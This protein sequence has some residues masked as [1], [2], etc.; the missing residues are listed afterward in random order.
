[1][2]HYTLVLT[3]NPDTQVMDDAF[4]DNLRCSLSLPLQTGEPRW[5][6]HGVALELPLGS[7]L[8]VIERNAIAQTT[9]EVVGDGPIDINIVADGPD[10]RKRL[11]LADMDSTI[12]EQECIDEIAAAAG[13]GEHVASITERAMRGELDFES[14]LRERV[15]LLA[16]LE[17]SALDHVY[18]DRITLT[19]GARVLTRTMAAH[20]AYC[21][22]VSGGFTYFTS[23]IADRAGFHENR[24]NRLD[25]SAQ[26]L[27]GQVVPPILGREAKR[28]ALIELRDAR[29]L[30]SSATMAVGDGANDLAMI[31]EAGLGVA[32]RAKPIVAAEAS[33]AIT[34]GDL[35]ALLFLQGYNFEEF[36]PAAD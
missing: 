22:L 11:L 27:T 3:S 25:I 20:G 14:A 19:P 34:H 24:A 2:I 4:A 33:A 15:A 6:C 10:R 1:M 17:S 9:R 29:A 31:R 8:T 13:I 32:F 7:T 16:G 35:T 18:T 30:P 28:D 5:L 12:I 23:R 36:A 21:A 26:R